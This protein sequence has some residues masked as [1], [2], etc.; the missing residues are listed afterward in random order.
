MPMADKRL[1]LLDDFPEE[2]TYEIG[3]GECFRL[4]LASLNNQKSTHIVLRV[5]ENASVELALALFAEGKGVI[6]IEAI[7]EEGTS[8][9]AVAST[10]ASGVSDK[11]VY[12]SAIHEGGSS[13]ALVESRGIVAGKSRLT[14]SGTG[15]IKHGAK[16]ANTRQ[17]ARIIVF[18]KGCFASA[19]PILKI[20]ENDVMASHGSA[21]GM[22]DE[23]HLFYLESRGIPE[24]EARRLITSGYLLPVLPYFSEEEQAKLNEAIERNL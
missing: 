2:A 19:S 20:D 6:D 16:K 18:D 21:E 10:I 3:P 12:L 7:L 8:F 15:H 14:L 11:K 4:S 1:S 23:Q 5:A 24:K 9:H 13:K 17:E 22:V